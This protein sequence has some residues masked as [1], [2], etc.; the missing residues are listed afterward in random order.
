MNAAQ[1][2]LWTGIVGGIAQMAGGISSPGNQGTV[3]NNLSPARIQKIDSS[4]YKLNNAGLKIS[5]QNTG[6]KKDGEET[7]EDRRK[8]MNDAVKKLLDQLSAFRNIKL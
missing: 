8:A 5:P 4:K 3:N 2:S 6:G 7:A 1:I